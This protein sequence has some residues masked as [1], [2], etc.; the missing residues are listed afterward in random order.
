MRGQVIPSVRI[1]K[2]LTAIDSPDG[3]I[4]HQGYSLA[5]SW[6]GFFAELT[7]ARRVKP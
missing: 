4:E 7:I 6:L 5:V 2:A 1:F 3:D